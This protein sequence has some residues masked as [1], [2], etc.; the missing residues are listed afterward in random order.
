MKITATWNKTDDRLIFES[1]N[2]AVC[3]WF[4]QTCNERNTKFSTADMITDVPIRAESSLKLIAEI[5]N[6]IDVLNK[7]M[8]KLKLPTITKPSDWFDQQQLNRIHK[9]WAR[10]RHDYPKLPE[11][12]YKVDKEVFDSYNQTNCHIH[13]IENSF[14]HSF[15]DNNNHWRVENPFKNEFFDWHVC[16]LS[17][18]Y[19]GHGREAFEKF[20]N[21]DQEVFV[22][23]LCNWDNLD[24]Q[25]SMNLVRPYRLLPPPAFL[26]WCQDQALIPH[27]NT[28]PLAN[29]IDWE[30]NLAEARSIITKNTEIQDNYFTLT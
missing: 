26:D 4:V 3:Q 30:T 1:I 19:P 6:A 7:F 15:R 21:F 5:N 25:I 12:L 9:D 17:L 24:S 10:T 14:H 2:D 13:L 16:H 27:T 11:L 23:D 8:V 28:L 20:R 22:D 29:L 18:S